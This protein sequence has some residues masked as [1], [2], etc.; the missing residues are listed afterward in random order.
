VAPPLTS[1]PDCPVIAVAWPEPDYLTALRRAGG[2][3]RVLTA[4]HDRLPA[5]L[6]GSSGL[7][8]TGG[9]DVDPRHYGAPDTHPTVTIDPARDEYELALA[10]DLPIF[11]ICRGVQLLNV[12]AGGTLLQDI[13][14]NPDAPVGHRR[15][16]RGVPVHEVKV[17]SGTCLAGL[18][19][20]RLSADGRVQVNSRHH[21]AVDAIAPGFVAA[22]TAPDGIIEAIERPSATFCLGV[23][24]HPENFWRTG[25]FAELFEGLISAARAR[26]EH[27]A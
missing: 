8:L 11:A 10:R 27:P 23:Q 9:A 25:E 15:Q 5:A 13:P 12:A 18:L 2:S 17:A 16:E 22:A 21:Q 19:D 26:S 7:L 3:P 14:A 20:R 4:E 24:W 1:P 6:D